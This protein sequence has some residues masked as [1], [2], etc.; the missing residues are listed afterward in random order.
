[1][2]LFVLTHDFIHRKF[3]IFFFLFYTS[4]IYY[5]L[6]LNNKRLYYKYNIM[7]KIIINKLLV[8]YQ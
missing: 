4:V 5:Y 8:Y 7:F 1:M 6:L 3:F 2:K